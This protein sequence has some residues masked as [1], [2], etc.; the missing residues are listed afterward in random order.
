VN[1]DPLDL[2]APAHLRRLRSKLRKL[3][4]PVL[5]IWG[6]EDHIFPLSCARS[7][8][9]RLPQSKLVTIPRCG[10][11]APLDATEEVARFVVDF[12]KSNA[13]PRYP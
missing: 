5:L 6:G 10:H 3:H 12:L 2:F 11:W 9:E 8:V 1:S 7:I 4:A 13:E